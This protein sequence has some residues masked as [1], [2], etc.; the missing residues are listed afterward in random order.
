MRKNIFYVIIV[1]LLV[2]GGI[3][4]YLQ[5][6]HKNAARKDLTLKQ[7]TELSPE[8][9]KKALEARLADL[10]TQAK[11]L[12][13]DTSAE[14][15]YVIYIGLAEVQIQLEKFQDALNSLNAIPTEKNKNSRVDFDYGF[16]YRGVG[17]VNNAKLY[18]SRGLAQDETN[19]QAWL[20]YID[21]LKG[22][23]AEQLDSMYAAAIKGTKNNLDVVIAYAKF[24]SSTGNKE[25]AI[26]YWETAR[27]I[28]PGGASEYD[29]EIAKLR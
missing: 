6:K 21:L 24:L 15:Q 27:N 19:A 2:A 4:G 7:V 9:K 17:D 11:A 18:L 22:S 23:K 25:K 14:G 20:A 28:N 8:E 16:A 29:A 13:K 12:T 26:G 3:Y 1:L 10:Q 5:Y